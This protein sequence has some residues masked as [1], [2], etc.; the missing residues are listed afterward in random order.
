MATPPADGS[1][2]HDDDRDP[3][4][5]MAESFLARFRRGERPSIDE[6]AA[7]YPDLADEIRELLPALVQLESDLSVGSATGTFD[8]GSRA[9]TLRGAPRRLGD[10]TILREV[11]RGGMGVVYEAVQQSLGRHV[12][13]KVLP[14]QELGDPSQL[15]R[16][17]LEA[18]SAARLH[19]SNIVPVF[20][21]G[22]H[23]GTHYYAM[24]FIRGQGL[25]QVI[26]ELR[27]LRNLPRTAPEQTGFAPPPATV[28]AT[29]AQG[30]MTGRFG[31][32]ATVADGPP[33]VPAASASRA[34]GTSAASSSTASALIHAPES[35][36][37]SERQYYRQ[38]A[39]IGL[40]VAEALGYAHGQGI[41]HRD[42]KPSN[43]LVDTQGTVWI[44]DFGLAKAEGSEGP[45]RT[46]D[47]V[48]TLRYMGPERFE[49][50]SDPRSDVYAL[51]ATLYELLTLEPV[52]GE[53]SR[54]KLIERILHDPPAAPRKLDR[55]IPRDLETIVLTA[56]AKEPHQRYA[57]AEAMA[58]DLRRF[59]ED[60]PIRARPVGTA[61]QVWRWC[62][63]RPAVASLLGLLLLLLVGETITATLAAHHFRGLARS[64][65]EARRQADRLAG[66]EREANAL[67]AQQAKEAEQARANAD[68][69]A[70]E[71]QA[72]ADF[73][74]IDLL[75][76]AQPGEGKGLATPVG[77]VLARADAAIASR[78]A[79]RP[80]VEA[81][82]RHRLGE[83]Y[84]ALGIL[85]KSEEHFRAAAD[86]R[87]K[88]LGPDDPDT[89]LSEQQ[90][91]ITLRQSGRRDEAL[92]LGQAVVERQRRVL[93]PEAAETL[94]TMGEIGRLLYAGRP[95][96]ARPFYQKL[97][98]GLARALGPEHF[99]TVNALHWYANT[100]HATR[101]YDRAE[102]L[103]R[104]VLDLRIRAGGEVDKAT[105]WMMADLIQLLVA[106]GKPEEAW[107]VA[108]RFWRAAFHNAD[109]EGHHLTSANYHLYLTAE[110]A[111]DWGRVE[112][113]ARSEAE[114]L[115]R[116]FGPDHPRALYARATLAYALVR[117]GAGRGG[118]AVLVAR[119][120]RIAAH[121]APAVARQMP[122]QMLREVLVASDDP[123]DRAAFLAALGDD[124]RSRP[125][126]ADAC[127]RAAWARLARGDSPG[128]V[129]LNRAASSRA[130]ATDRATTAFFLFWEGDRTGAAALY[131]EAIRLAPD[132]GA[133]E[134]LFLRLAFQG[135]WLHDPALALLLDKPTR[136][137]PA[138]DYERAL[139]L[140]ALGRDEPSY[141]RAARALLDR[142]EAGGDA[143]AA[144][145]A[146]RACAISPAPVVDPSRVAA[147]ALRVPVDGRPWVPYVAGLA[148]YRAGRFE[149]AI[150]QLTKSIE[151][152]PN[153]RAAPLNW[154]VLAMA[155]HRL[156]HAEEA[157]RWLA[158]ADRVRTWEIPDAWGSWWDAVEFWLLRREA[159]ALILGPSAGPDAETLVDPV[160]TATFAA[161]VG[162]LAAIAPDLEPADASDPKVAQAKNN[163]AW[164]LVVDPAAPADGVA[165]ALRLARASVAAGPNHTNRTTLGVALYRAG[166]FGPAI[167]ELEASD[168]LDA[169]AY[170]SAH[171]GL[172][173]AMAH[174][175]LGHAKEAADYLDRSAAWMKSHPPGTPELQRLRSEAEAVVRFDPIFP[176]DPF[177]R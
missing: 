33:A 94:V 152:G 109:P 21:V 151:A 96:E 162:R 20:G 78:F 31:A 163:A 8:G 93:G 41:V 169:N 39:R 7:K 127:R 17:A 69:R 46:G 128:A 19:H 1:P 54:P 137:D 42:I 106:A 24:Q 144:Y 51:G 66:L 75:M 38:V 32:P 123:A 5:L 37:P 71:A 114:A 11:G 140:L 111:H 29:V 53:A 156:A 85:P 72:V 91:M 108:A 136:T 104:Q 173:L 150:R 165:L 48:G 3:I 13:L 138:A 59:V 23:D 88:N 155:H 167:A 18:R 74:V 47:I 133:T 113:L 52:F 99:R 86:L 44:T 143:E 28:A 101:E 56:L 61:E 83:T 135:P 124:V 147:L 172:F 9:A 115:G 119:M 129:A 130:G 55:H 116:E 87:R 89:L 43:L 126:F 110:A 112:A 40:Q 25:D 160:A 60:L 10:Y 65:S 27:R 14:W 134:A 34:A 118:D 132:R 50:R 120:I 90:H 175:R 26:A 79:G 161:S 80:V 149:E 35:H 159:R 146:A 105:W 122:W 170:V 100:F 73:L 164:A 142:A 117:A 15:E 98:E 12:A 139:L 62:R 84:W 97:H 57:D 63:R 145:K 121:S 6:Y 131:R 30:L 58:E 177:A 92:K 102:A 81:A 49:G 76:A 95:L 154:P 4:D 157:S 148:L 68:R 141:R 22:E 153:W 103:Y 166:E 64:E 158:R 70:A 2:D 125:E 174:R 36:H 16:F 171:N 67:A 107:P 77:E 45:T 168:R 176:A 82:I